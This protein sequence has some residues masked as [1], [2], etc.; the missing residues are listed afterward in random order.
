MRNYYSNIKAKDRNVAL[1]VIL[2][3]RGRVSELWKGTTPVIFSFLSGEHLWIL[4]NS[5]HFAS[6]WL[7][8]RCSATSTCTQAG[9]AAY[10]IT[11]PGLN[12]YSLHGSNDLESSFLAKISRMNFA[13]ENILKY[14]HA[15]EYYI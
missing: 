8:K 5:S 10:C 9:S 13:K 6:K 2:I 7:V 4:R 11:L 1:L 12:S 14:W 15:G 3:E